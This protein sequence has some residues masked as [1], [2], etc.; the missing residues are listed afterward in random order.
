MPEDINSIW[1]CSDCLFPLPGAAC[2]GR[3]LVGTDCTVVRLR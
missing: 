2:A 1:F 3:H